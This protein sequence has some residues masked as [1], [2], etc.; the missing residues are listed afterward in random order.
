[1]LNSLGPAA[2]I[3][4]FAAFGFAFLSALAQDTAPVRVWTGPSVNLL[5]QP[6]S[7]APIL[8]FV[9]SSTGDIALRELDTGTTRR[10]TNNQQGGEFAYFS[11]LSPDASRVA[12]AW[13]NAERFYEL[14]VIATGGGAPRTLYRN[15][16]SAFIQPCAFSPDGAW[17]L[18]LFF[19][20]DN[21]SQIALVNAA[22]GSVR[23]LKSLN[24]TYPRKMSFSPDGR[25]IVYD[26]TGRDGYEQ[27]AIAVLAADGSRDTPLVPGPGNNV[28]PVWHG[29]R[30]YF[31]SDRGGAWG[32]WSIAVNDGKPAGEPRLERAALGRFLPLGISGGRYYYGVRLDTRQVRIAD[33]KDESAGSPVAAV[34]GFAPAWSADG[35]RLAFLV[36]AGAENFG[37]D[38]RSIVVWQPGVAPVV[39]SPK[40][41][42][43]RWVRFRPDGRLLASGSDRN[44]RQGL[45]FVDAKD[46]SLEP[47]LRQPGGSEAGLDAVISADGA[48]V[49][50]VRER[51][52]VRRDVGS[53]EET[54]LHA[55][56]AV[57]RE[58]AMSPDGGAVAFIATG[59]RDALMMLPLKGGHPVQ[60]AS[61][62]RQGFQSIEWAPN[63]SEIYV[64]T[65]TP[66]PGLWRVAMEG[67]APVRLPAKFERSGGI[68]LAP[69]GA[70]VAYPAG[71]VAL[72]VR[73]LDLGLES[74]EPRR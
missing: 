24:W 72:E 35:Q 43:L 3:A 51:E 36:A 33:W 32:L 1:M 25:Y 68:R 2:R 20:R 61:A 74:S 69:D 28:F 50:F 5:G 40:L 23:V 9:D 52:I 64:S 22:T 8:S 46:G 55:S 34:P 26:E 27:G 70:R 65:N 66:P 11:A 17:I 49:I 38:S 4:R 71:G 37:R 45:Y 18:T 14:R 42:G 53:G 29:E 47:V 73:V 44:G 6:A 58:L 67:G 30:V 31:S 10:L 56:S 15:E 59:E 7:R 21:A 57:P 12:Y 54:V 62:A 63:G 48:F 39:I 16:E 41:A 13:Y 19:R 60:L